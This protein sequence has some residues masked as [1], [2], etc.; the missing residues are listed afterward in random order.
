M[1]CMSAQSTMTIFDHS[2]GGRVFRHGQCHVATSTTTLAFWLIGA[3][4][5][6]VAIGGEVYQR[7]RPGQST[8]RLFCAPAN[9]V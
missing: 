3:R 9:D 5:I 1:A 6:Q 2:S 8:H 7:N 4:E